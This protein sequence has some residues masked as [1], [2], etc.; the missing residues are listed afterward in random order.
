MLQLTESLKLLFMLLIPNL[1]RLSFNHS[2]HLRDNL[3][4]QAHLKHTR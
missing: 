3:R 2:I 4:S 1:T